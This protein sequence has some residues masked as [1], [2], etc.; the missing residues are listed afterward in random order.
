MSTE[1]QKE[2]TEKKFED[3]VASGA[4]ETNLVD[5]AKDLN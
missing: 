4:I 3:Y 1:A 2:T 5:D